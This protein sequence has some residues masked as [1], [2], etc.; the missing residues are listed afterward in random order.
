MVGRSFSGR[1][2]K[3]PGTEA[4]ADPPGRARGEPPRRFA[5]I[6]RDQ[7]NQIQIENSDRQPPARAPRRAR[8]QVVDRRQREL[9]RHVPERPARC[10]PA[11]RS[12]SAHADR[13]G[14]GSEV[15][16]L[17]RALAPR[18]SRPDRAAASSR[19]RR[20]A[21]LSSLQ[22]QVVRCLC[23]PWLEGASLDELPSNEQIAAAARHAR[24]GRDRQGRAPAGV[25]EGRSRRRQPPHAKRRALCRVA[26][27]ARLGLSPTRVTSSDH[28]ALPSVSPEDTEGKGQSCASR[29]SSS[30]VSGSTQRR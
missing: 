1:L 19:S 9:Q 8:R 26:Q 24:I 6:G 7:V 15:A 2:G 22:L 14:V 11:S 27:P 17:L 12:S 25:L 3:P 10:R 29:S 28:L 21:Q 23:G 18:R 30:A 5:S 16:R 20:V 13:I 4:C